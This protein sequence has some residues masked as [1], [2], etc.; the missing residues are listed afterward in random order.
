[1]ILSQAILGGKK[2]KRTF[3]ESWLGKYS[4]L[5]FDSEKNVMTCEICKKAGKTNA[6][7]TGTN[8]FRLTTILRHLGQYKKDAS[9]TVDTDHMQAVHELSMAGTVQK[10]NEKI[11]HEKERAI[12][13]AI[14]SVLWLAKE[15]LPIHKYPNLMDFL[16][17]LDCPHINELGMQQNTSYRSET[18]ANDIVECLAEAL[19]KRID[20]KMRK[21]MFISLLCDESTDTST[22]KKLIVYT[23][24]LDPETF[25][26]NTTF[27]SNVFVPNG[28]GET[29][30]DALVNLLKEKEI[31]ISKIM[32][33]GSD[34][35]AVMTGKHHDFLRCVC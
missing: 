6:L 31:S 26:V 24:T 22:A 13:I 18:T 10:M 2:I 1:M 12:M 4:W 19:R 29:I 30:T 14:K 8:N 7:A 27:V 20:E 17:D 5:R 34:S 16:E 35:A 3:S 21:S 15:Q 28:T 9:R 33:F 11:F 32:G 23:I 25:D